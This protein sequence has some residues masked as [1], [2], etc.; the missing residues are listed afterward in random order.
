MGG[1]PYH[2]VHSM[3]TNPVYAGA[4]AFGK[5]RRERY[6]DE[7]GQPSPQDTR[8]EDPR[9]GTQ[10]PPTIPSTNQRCEDRLNPGRSCAR[11]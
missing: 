7:H 4:Y 1:A 8:M 2:Q 3:L 5:T 10:R 9:R 11:L 6:V